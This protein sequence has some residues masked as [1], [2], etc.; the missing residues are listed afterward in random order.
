[1]AHFCALLDM[2]MPTSKGQESFRSCTGRNVHQ[3]DGLGRPLISNVE[4]LLE[5]ALRPGMNRQPQTR[6]TTLLLLLF[7]SQKI[8]DHK[9]V[10]NNRIGKKI[11]LP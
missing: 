9:P 8:N 10:E 5:A 1:M 6:C 11:N 7:Y 3:F 4:Y 2:K